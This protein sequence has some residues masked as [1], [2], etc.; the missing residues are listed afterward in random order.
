MGNLINRNLP[1]KLCSSSDAAQEYE[2]GFYCFS[3]QGHWKREDQVKTAPKDP[4]LSKVS[5]LSIHGYPE[6]KISKEI[7][8]F[9]KVRCS[10]T[11]EGKI[12]KYYYPVG[13]GWKIKTLEPKGIRT[14]GK[15]DD[16]FGKD[17]FKE[18]GRRIVVTEGEEDCL[19][20]AQAFK[21]KYGRV[22]PVVSLG[23]C[24]SLK[25]ISINM[26]FFSN[27]EEVIVWMD[28]DPP[29]KAA[30]K[31]ILDLL[32][33]HRCKVVESSE[34]DASDL[35]V[36]RGGLEVVRATW[37]AAAKSPASIVEGKD[38]WD[39]YNKYIDMTY[40]P[41]PEFL[42]ELNK[43]TYGRYLGTITMFAAG[44]GVGK[45]TLLK[46]DMFHLLKNMDSGVGACFLEEDIG[47]TVT[48]LMSLELNKRLGLPDTEVS[49]EEE[50][51]AWKSV[52]GSNR[53][54]LIDHQGSVS[55][56]TLIS[57][58]DY[59]AARGCKFIYLDHI[60]V[61]VSESDER[62]TNKAIDIFMSDLLKLVKRRNI[63]MGVVSHLRKVSQGKESFESGGKIGED[64]LKGSGSLK[65][66][67]FQTVSL[68]RDKL[69]NDVESRHVTS[70]T[71]LK[72]RKT[73]NAGPA[74]FVKF[75]PIT[76]R[77]KEHCEGLDLC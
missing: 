42:G 50:K 15:V 24:T 41:W 63:W 18:S 69:S 43:M 3:C 4:E 28:N 64:D 20:V 71:L 61:A 35:L 36:K 67:S 27:F 32:G 60:T 62:D 39:Y 21:H 7:M 72:D 68:S 31:R 23:S 48:S 74:G 51:R 34:K 65:Q 47:E 12:D 2:D 11:E 5:D 16:L 59:M 49:K 9:F 19:S 55:D 25:N 6:R 22:Y 52:F 75:D 13:Q 58:L 53:I 44:T 73:G 38:T 8:E 26:D 76:G 54:L 77:L 40:V 17:L 57:K 66:I 33:Y 30:A 46:E 14:V 10:F 37:N 56:G 1:C 45:S 70:L 29:G